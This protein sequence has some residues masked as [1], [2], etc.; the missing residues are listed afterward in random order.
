MKVLLSHKKMN[1]KNINRRDF[2]A[3]KFNLFIKEIPSEPRKE[4]I[5]GDPSPAW[6][7]LIIPFFLLVA[8]IIVIYS[9]F[10]TQK[11]YKYQLEEW[12]KITKTIRLENSKISAELDKLESNLTINAN[13]YADYVLRKILIAHSMYVDD[14]I[15]KAISDG[16]VT[17][18]ENILSGRLGKIF[19]IARQVSTPAKYTADIV[20]INPQNM[21]MWVIEVDGSYHQKEEMILKDKAREPILLN[22]GINII[23]VSNS[24]I[25]SDLDNVMTSIIKAMEGVRQ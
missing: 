9:Y 7:I 11:Y 2:F 20:S 23:R 3:Y 18:Y 15:E 17:H 5:I 12:H 4:S 24:E 21:T 25:I 8:I 6:I 13:E 10:K 16:Y 14:N 22:N 19:P 1:Y